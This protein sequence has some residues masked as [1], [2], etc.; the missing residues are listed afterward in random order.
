MKKTQEEGKKKII[1]FEL[2]WFFPG[3]PSDDVNSWFKNL[4]GINYIIK[5][6]PREDY[7]LSIPNCD[8]VNVKLREERLEI[9]WRSCKEPFS[10]IDGKIRGIEER[11]AKWAWVTDPKNS[12]S[13]ESFKIEEPF[14]PTFKITKT[15]NI[16][17]YQVSDRN[18]QNDLQYRNPMEQIIEGTTG[19]SVEIT[20]LRMLDQSWWTLAFETYGTA[21]RSLIRIVAEQ[22][23]STY[24]GPTLTE[25]AS[26]GYSHWLATHH[27]Q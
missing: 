17:H 6:P 27:K 24:S 8:Y 15:R 18:V 21:E 16:R 22:S 14:G 12:K 3:D 1:S 2:R 25:G 4:D 20:S 19:Y 11:W 7:Q 9:K 23:L 5:E 10:A 13:Y 26:Y